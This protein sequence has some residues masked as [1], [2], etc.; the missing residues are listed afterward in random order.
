MLYIQLIQ[1]GREFLPRD[2]SLRHNKAVITGIKDS[3]FIVIMKQDNSF[4][5]VRMKD[6]VLSDRVYTDAEL[7]SGSCEFFKAVDAPKKFNDFERFK[8]LF[9]KRVVE[10]LI[11]EKKLRG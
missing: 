4:E 6:V 5:I 1:L 11:A 3:H 8:M 9:E 10:E 2:L 7:K